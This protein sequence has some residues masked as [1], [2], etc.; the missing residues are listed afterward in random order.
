MAS[1]V[2]GELLDSPSPLLQSIAASN[3][4]IEHVPLRRNSSGGA[5][6]EVKEHRG[7]TRSLSWDSGMANETYQTSYAPRLKYD[8]TD[9]REEDSGSLAF[10][11][12]ELPFFHLDVLEDTLSP[13]PVPPTGRSIPLRMN[14]P[15]RGFAPQ[16]LSPRAIALRCNQG[17]GSDGTNTALRQEEEEVRVHKC[18]SQGKVSYVALI[19]I[20]Q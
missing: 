10:Y 13:A 1:L 17:V 9:Q 11:L 14:P 8:Q 12:D 2:I 6:L 5:R 4:E 20:N 15:A 19:Y 18:L 3:E 16:N 7:R